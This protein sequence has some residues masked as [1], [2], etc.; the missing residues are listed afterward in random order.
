MKRSFS[1]KKASVSAFLLF[2]FFAAGAAAV[3]QEPELVATVNGAGITKAEFERSWPAF[4]RQKGIP[5]NHSEKSGQVDEFRLELLNL[6]IDQE[7]LY[8]AAKSGGHEAGEEQVSAEVAKARGQFPSEEEF[9]KALSGSGLTVE[10]Y[11]DFLRHRISVFN[12]VRD[13]VAPGVTVSD[14]EISEFYAGNLQSFSVP[15]QVRARHI[16]IKVDP[17]ADEAAKAEAKK[18]IEGVIVKARGGAGFAELAKEYSQGPSAPR[19][20]DLG[21][22]PRGKMVPPFDEAVF[23]LEVGEISGPVLT[24]FG[25]H[26]IKVE[27]K[28]EA[29]TVSEEEAAGQIK[30]F[31]KEKKVAEAVKVRLESL[32]ENAKIENKL[33]N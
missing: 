7:L 27:E 13:D 1:M 30:D 21:L 8:Q 24:R 26:A 22:F 31:L 19:G 18:E 23:S 11:T 3:G 5:V 2:L 20:G 14:E 16:L 25:Y 29:T 17:K 15:E 28:Q 6:L 9:E 12:M 32:K 4:L 10:S 33:T